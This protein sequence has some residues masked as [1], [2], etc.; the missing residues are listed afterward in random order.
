[1]LFKILQ[2]PSNKIGTE[3]TALHEGWAYFTP[4]TG[5]FYI[6]AKVDDVLQRIQINPERV[7]QAVRGDTTYAEIVEAH[8]N[9]CVVVC[10]D[11]TAVCQLYSINE[12]KKTALFISIYK[13]DANDV[14]HIRA[15]DV[16]EDDAGETT[17][18]RRSKVTTEAVVDSVTEQNAKSEQK[19][20]RGTKEEFDAIETKDDSVMYIVTDDDEEEEVSTTGGFKILDYYDTL[21]ALQTAV[22]VPSVGDAYGIGTSYPYDIYVYSKSSG[23]V[24]NG[25]IQGPKGDPFTYADFTTEQLAALTGPTGATGAKGDT[26][27]TGATGPANTLTIGTVTGGTTASA[28]ITG[29]APNQTL[30][31]VL[32]KGATGAT[33]ATGAKGDTGETG[34]T[35]PAGT[36]VTHSWSGTNLTLTSAS[37][38]TTTDLGLKYTYGTTDLTAGVSA[39]ATGTLY[40]V[41][42]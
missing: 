25:S 16:T 28:T 37:G 5:G 12:A 24:N 13:V 20:W 3:T 17:W 32:P 39:L 33:G 2:G 22:T 34:A 23:W 9:G 11:G 8:N 18:T 15:W 41:Y 27:A 29:T 35:G 21:S 30:N 19:F 14:A 31:L 10:L 7:F 40:F 4:D 26:G 1:M 36:S 38:T 42:E 6:D